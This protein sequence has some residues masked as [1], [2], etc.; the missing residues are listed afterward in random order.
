MA[1]IMFSGIIIGCVSD[2]I[3]LLYYR[4]NKERA[5]MFEDAVRFAIVK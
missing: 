4:I 5:T 2:I 1:K 3:N